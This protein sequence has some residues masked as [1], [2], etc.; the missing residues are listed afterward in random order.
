M[1]LREQFEKETGWEVDFTVDD[2]VE[3]FVMGFEYY[4]KY[5][6]WLE[7]QLQNKSSA[8]PKSCPSCGQG[9][10]IYIGSCGNCGYSWA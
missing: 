3:D 1:T 9:V 5:S 6:E 8:T 10:A 7:K 2:I 4:E